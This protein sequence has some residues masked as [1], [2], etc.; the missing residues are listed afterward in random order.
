MVLP[1]GIKY[2]SCFSLNIYHIEIWYEVVDL[3][4][5]CILYNLSFVLYS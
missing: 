1:R 5:L 3:N 2:F 4:E